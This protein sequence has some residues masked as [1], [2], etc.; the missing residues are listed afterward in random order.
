MNEPVAT[1]LGLSSVCPARAFI[2]DAQKMAS[3]LLLVNV[4]GTVTLRSKDA[5]AVSIVATNAVLWQACAGKRNLKQS[6]QQMAKFCVKFVGIL[7][8]VSI[9][10]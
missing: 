10:E 9:L 5:S 8:M 2:S 6:S 1:T 7:L 4:M 3:P